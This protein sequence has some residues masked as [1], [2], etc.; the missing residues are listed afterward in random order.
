M[1]KK[2]ILK[3][4]CVSISYLVSFLVAF[5]LWNCFFWHSLSKNIKEHV[6]FLDYF[7]QQTFIDFISYIAGPIISTYQILEVMVDL[8]KWADLLDLLIC[9]LSIIATVFVLVK[10]FRKEVNPLN[11]KYFIGLLITGF[12]WFLWGG[13]LR[14]F[15]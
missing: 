10:F 1:D 7:L 13:Y 6:G 15:I 2:I 5:V 12:F 14:L 11:I 3:I 8:F 9:L 4:I